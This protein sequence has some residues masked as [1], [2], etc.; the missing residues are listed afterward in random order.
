MNKQKPDS[1]ILTYVVAGLAVGTAVY[2][3][4]QSYKGKE[5]E[6]KAQAKLDASAKLIPKSQEERLKR[7]RS[8][9]AFGS[10]LPGQTEIEQKIG[11]ST[12]SAI[13]SFKEVGNQA[14]FQ[15]FIA[16]SMQDEQTKLVDLGIEAAKFKLDRSKDVDAALGDMSDIE[17]ENIKR[18]RELEEAKLAEALANKEAGAE[19]ISSGVV[20]GATAIGSTGGD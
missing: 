15:D 11:A 7:I 2:G 13:T 12:S 16:Q 10:E 5:D 17:Q 14:N 6:K 9:E 1:I 3:G 4:Y 8:R 18:K 20:T 19:N